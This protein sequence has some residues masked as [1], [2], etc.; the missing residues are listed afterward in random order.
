MTIRTTTKD[1][2]TPKVTS[3]CSGSQAVGYYCKRT[4]NGTNSRDLDH[5]TDNAYVMTI[6]EFNNPYLVC[7]YF[8]TTPH[9]TV[10]FTM[11]CRFG[12]VSI[13]SHL[14][15]GAGAE[16]ILLDRIADQVR[17]NEF[18]LGTCLG[19]AHESVMMIGNTARTLVGVIL[20]IKKGRFSSAARRLGSRGMSGTMSLRKTLAQNW[21]ALQY[22]WMPLLNDVYAAS[23]GISNILNKPHKK[24]FKAQ[25]TIK[26]LTDHQYGNQRTY[27]R[28]EAY[29]KK[30]YILEL[31]E[32]QFPSVPARLGLQDPEVVA[33]ELLPFSFIADWFLPIGDYLSLRAN[34]SRLNGKWIT[35]DLRVSN[36]HLNIWKSTDYDWPQT[37]W[38]E[39]RYK[40]VQFNRTISSSPPK[41]PLPKIRPL[42]ESFSV[43]HCLSGLALLAQR[44]L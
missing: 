24:R 2:R 33:W 40:K 18:D 37:P 7:K 14:T 30:G 44:V 26:A 19:E 22:G 4:Q 1:L 17:N 25:Y 10:S 13:P 16:S 31:S 42:T 21:L 3:G 9:P 32:A 15:W 36:R 29:R 28:Q 11:Q 38:P 6:D 27:F 23:E 8:G 41:V 12:A 5:L 34:V 39:Y 20:D 43:K 35:S